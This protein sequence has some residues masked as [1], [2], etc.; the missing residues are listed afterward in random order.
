MQ[1]AI[2]KIIAGALTFGCCLTSAFAA[3]EFYKDKRVVI[4]VNYAAGGPTDI[5]ARVLMRHLPKHLPGVRSVVVQN[6]DGAGGLTGTNYLGEVA[7]KDGT[8]VG[9]LTGTAFQYALK[10]QGRRVDYLKY[11]FIGYQP[12][13][14]IYFM[15]ADIKPGMKTATDVMKAQNLI[16]GGLGVDNAKDILLRLTLDI[17]G[18]KNYGYVTAYKGSAGA[19]IAFQN[20]EVNFYSESPPSYRS[21]IQPALVD[22]GMAVPVF[23]DPNYDGETFSTTSQ[24]AGLDILPFH[25]LYKKINGKLPEGELWDVYKTIISLNGAMQRLIVMPPGVPKEAA[26]TMRA[27]IASING[28]KAYAQDAVKTFGFIPEWT[29]NEQVGAKVR[30]A[31]VLP[32]KVRAF[33]DKYIAN[34]PKNR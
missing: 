1:K 17:L 21:V 32:P 22:K 12:G 8:V 19:R 2:T 9:Y 26:D 3:G 4:L 24:T 20:G 16:S 30:K 15:R 31:L 5:E 7:P 25:E 29:A 28:D 34:P 6:M 10:P 13:T 23:Y 14:S 11:N 27:A 18:V 33:L